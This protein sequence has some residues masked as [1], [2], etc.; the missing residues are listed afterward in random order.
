MF[1]GLSFTPDWCAVDQ[2]IGNVLKPVLVWAF[3]IS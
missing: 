1:E 2:Q 3:E